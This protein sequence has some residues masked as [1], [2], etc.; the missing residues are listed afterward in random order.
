VNCKTRGICTLAKW[1][2]ILNWQFSSYC[3]VS[4]LLNDIPTCLCFHKYIYELCFSSDYRCWEYVDFPFSNQTNYLDEASY[5]SFWYTFHLFFWGSYHLSIKQ[6]FG[7][8]IGM[9]SY[10]WLIPLLCK[11]LGFGYG[12]LHGRWVWQD[13]S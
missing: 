1:E 6:L 3:T 11:L 10:K 13:E 4:F 2:A 5:L 9:Q 8:S 12:Y 7:V